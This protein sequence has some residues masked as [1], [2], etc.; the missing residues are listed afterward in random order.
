VSAPAQVPA[1][2]RA[3]Q[4]AMMDRGDARLA[5]AGEHLAELART[6]ADDLVMI[7]VQKIYADARVMSRGDQGAVLEAA[8][9]QLGDQATAADG[10]RPPARKSDGPVWPEGAR[11]IDGAQLAAYVLEGGGSVHQATGGTARRALSWCPAVLRVLEAYADDGRVMARYY[12]L[13]ARGRTVT[14]S[15]DELREGLPWQLLPVTG[16]GS[17]RMRELL[18][19]IVQDQAAALEAEPAI[20][21]TGWHR[22]ADGARFYVHADGRAHDGRPILLYRPPERAALALAAAP[23]PAEVPAGDMIAALFDIAEHGRGPALVGLGLGVRALGQSLHPAPGGLVAVGRMNSG[24]S[25]VGWHARLPAL[26]RRDK[27]NAWPPL[28]TATFRD[29]ITSVELGLDYE[30]DMAGLLDDAALHRGSTRGDQAHAA[31]VCELAFRS[32]FNGTPIKQRS[33][34]FMQ[35]QAARYVRALPVATLQELPPQVQESLLTRVLLLTLAGGEVD[36][37][38]YKT[39][40]RRLVAPIRGLAEQ[41]VIPRL[42]QADAADYLAARDAE[43]LAMLEPYLDAAVPGWQAD[44]NG[45]ARV[46][47]IAAAFLAGLLIV[48]DLLDM[49]PGLAEGLL[50]PY[51]GDTLAEQAELLADDSAT[52]SPEAALADLLAAA[53]LEARAHVCD[54]EGVPN[55]VIPGMSEQEQGLEARGGDRF[56]GPSWRGYGAPL[57]WLPDDDALGVRSE[58]LHALIKRATDPRLPA[59]NKLTLPR[60]LVGDGLALPSGQTDSPYVRQ[61]KIGGD[62]RRLVMLRGTLLT[63]PDDSV[64]EIPGT[65]GTPGTV[66]VNGLDNPVPN[67]V[68]DPVPDPL[69]ATGDAQ[70]PAAPPATLPA[71]IGADQADDGAE[72]LPLEAE[73]LA[74][75][76]LGARVADTPRPAAPAP[77]AYGRRDAASILMA[78]GHKVAMPYGRGGPACYLLDGAQVTAEQLEAAARAYEAPAAERPATAVVSAPE[79][80]AVPL[81]EPPADDDDQADDDGHQGAEADDDQVMPAGVIMCGPRPPT[82]SDRAAVADFARQLADLGPRPPRE[83]RPYLVLGGDGRAYGP[84]G[85]VLTLPPGRLEQVHSYADLGAL[86]LELTTWRLWLPRPARELLGLPAQVPDLPPGE[87]WPH[88]F[89][90]AADPSAWGMHP[91]RPRG[92]A[93][94]VDLWAEPRPEGARALGVGV[95]EWMSRTPALAD[96]GPAELAR[97]LDLVHQATTTQAGRAGVAY[98]RSPGATYKHLLAQAAR[99]SRSGTPEAVAPPPPYARGRGRRGELRLRPP[100]GYVAPPAEV[101]AGWVLAR[102]DV[103]QCFASAAQSTTFGLGEAEHVKPG[104]LGDEPGAHLVMV[105]GAREVG[106]HP[107]L[108]PWIPAEGRRRDAIAWLDTLAA[109]WLAERGV[110][111]EV[112]ESYIWPTSARVF[113]SASGRLGAAVT[114]YRAE[115]TPEH[116]AAAAVIKAMSNQ[117]LGGWLASDFGGDRAPDDW[118]HRPDWWARVRTQAEARKQRNLVPALEAGALVVLAADQVDSVY[119]AAASPADLLA[120]PGTGGKP[121]I[122]SVRAVADRLPAD[123]LAA[124]E[125]EQ[126]PEVRGKFKLEQLAEVTPDLG[127][128]LADPRGRPDARRVAIKA[129]LA[130][131]EGQSG[132][133]Q[134]E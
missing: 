39:N 108:M 133:T 107:S 125:A 35:P 68:P 130:H 30:A 103:N 86:A 34:K 100:G 37:A 70:A 48:C 40:S 82:P 52:G 128:Q 132:T 77:I 89:A 88:P 11:V 67:P 62:K 95:P 116:L 4:V 84:G 106:V 49:S 119:V 85:E 45:I 2:A 25:S 80:E 120:A 50:A 90:E 99:W 74:E 93:G 69:P 122:V 102:L 20:T 19:D 60:R 23:P 78:H 96:L 32:L 3:E 123:V 81:P 61:V 10:P 112:L 66:Q 36:T 64:P 8:R 42:A 44:G 15:E 121:L 41:L 75:A 38:W 14:V 126:R 65:P 101:P 47:D 16:T 13:A 57:Y 104:R 92:L 114:R 110:P 129:A 28:V 73:Q 98:E 97:A 12:E 76:L 91:G 124:F 27:P 56:G 94:W 83:P 9:R 71:E 51:L 5:A 115:G 22:A 26:A 59:G 21:R 53:L 113:D 134:G 117:Y 55:P 6:G 127:R 118:H 7:R 54:R 105:R 79:A 29:T 43:A 24:K 58:A 33:S 17:K 72:V 63:P 46:I 87:G 131:A 111:L 18:T 31:D 109:R 1:I